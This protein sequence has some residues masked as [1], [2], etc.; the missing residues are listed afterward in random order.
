MLCQRVLL[1]NGVPAAVGGPPAWRLAAPGADI[2]GIGGAGDLLRPV[3]GERHV[4]AG[5]GSLPALSRAV[6]RMPLRARVRSRASGRARWP[7]AGAVGLPGDGDRQHVDVMG[8]GTACR[9]REAWTGPRGGG[10]TDQGD[11]GSGGK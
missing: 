10:M 3:P 5:R 8:A 4:E 1:R 6:R 11:T 9:D 7:V 2:L